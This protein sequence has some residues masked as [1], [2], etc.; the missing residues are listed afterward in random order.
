MNPGREFQDSCHDARKMKNVLHQITQEM[1]LKSWCKEW[2][3][4]SEKSTVETQ[5]DLLCMRLTYLLLDLLQ[6]VPHPFV[7]QKEEGPLPLGELG[8]LDPQ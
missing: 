8:Q 1:L 4:S 3:V 5:L 6:M 7:L 2:T